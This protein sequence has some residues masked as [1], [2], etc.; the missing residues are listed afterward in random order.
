MF[1]VDLA[2]CT[3]C[4]HCIDV[5][6]GGAISLEQGK[7][8]IDQDLCSE[9]SACFQVCETGA[10]QEVVRPKVAQERVPASSSSQPPETM[11]E[12]VVPMSGVPRRPQTRGSDIVGPIIS[13]APVAAALLSR[14]ARMWLSG[15]GVGARRDGLRQDADGR[16]LSPRGRGAG[17]RGSGFGLGGGRR[18]RGRRRRW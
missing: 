5:C 9:C 13:L 17:L 7:A 15:R 12:T 16:W 14:L 11:A 6:H 3:G 10:I 18:R 4:G 1:Q 2:R 8:V